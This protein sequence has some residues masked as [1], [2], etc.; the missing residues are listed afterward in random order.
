M[1]V[2]KHS[3]GHRAG[4]SV[5][6]E[7]TYKV[8]HKPFTIFLNDN[9]IQHNLF[10]FVTFLGNEAVHLVGQ[11]WIMQSKLVVM[12][13]LHLLSNQFFSKSKVCHIVLSV[14]ASVF[15]VNYINI[16]N[17]HLNNPEKSF[18]HHFIDLSRKL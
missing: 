2:L 18:R 1:I 3:S 9:C 17:N 13:G 8:K 10:F 6:V 4:L 7:Q 15:C 16:D 5:H 11:Y 12:S 14:S